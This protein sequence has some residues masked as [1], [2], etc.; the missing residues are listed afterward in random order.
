M[1]FKLTI[2]FSS[3][4]PGRLGPMVTCT[5]KLGISILNGGNVLV[6]QVS[7]HHIITGVLL[8]MF[9][10][11]LPQMYS[12]ITSCQDFLCMKTWVLRSIVFGRKCWITWKRKETQAFSRVCQASC[13]PAGN[14]D[15]AT[16]ITQST[17]LVLELPGN[18]DSLLI[19]FWSTSDKS[20]YCNLLI[21]MLVIPNDI[22][23][24]PS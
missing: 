19:A 24:W 22:I 12:V 2:V 10:T 1:S 7:L 15:Y 11:S 6:Q 17:D 3:L 5:L 21:S 14:R 16:Q 4:S 18:D 20:M 9:D 23:N 8:C 13:S